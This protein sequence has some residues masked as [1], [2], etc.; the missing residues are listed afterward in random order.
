MTGAILVG[1]HCCVS[2]VVGRGRR[3]RRKAQQC[4]IAVMAVPGQTP[5]KARRATS[6]SDGGLTQLNGQAA[7]RAASFE[8]RC[9]RPGESPGASR[10][11]SRGA[12]QLRRLGRISPAVT[13]SRIREVASRRNRARGQRRQRRA[14]AAALDGS[15]NWR[16]GHHAALAAA[17]CVL[18][19][20]SGSPI[21][22]KL[23][24]A[25]PR[26]LSRPRGRGR[27]LRNRRPAR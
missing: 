19:Q 4:R 27:L 8:R 20:D 15:A 23:P 1:I 22:T 11:P 17:P 12:R 2:S 13:E 16:H 9:G 3:G 18:M 6:G 21:T 24:H 25:R 7:D 26:R 5:R 14:A 10:Q